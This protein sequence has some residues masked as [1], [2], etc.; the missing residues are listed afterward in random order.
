MIP[1]EVVR[2]R[3]FIGQRFKTARLGWLRFRDR[4]YEKAGASQVDWPPNILKRVDR[5]IP[6][7]G[8]PLTLECLRN[9]WHFMAER[10]TKYARKTGQPYTLG[11]IIINSF[12]RP[13]GETCG[14]GLFRD[15]HGVAD[16]TD[17]LGHWRMSV[18]L[19][20]EQTRL[21]FTPN[22][23]RGSVL[24]CLRKARLIQPISCECW[25]WRPKRK[26]RKAYFKKYPENK[27]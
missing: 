4:N 20:L 14:D 25:H 3:D 5:D 7:V 24:R 9:A 1:N 21:S 8:H 11:H 10:V 15:P 22:L 16:T 26:V 19:S 27:L 2:W 6:E 13:P 17:A 23:R 12:Y 18:D